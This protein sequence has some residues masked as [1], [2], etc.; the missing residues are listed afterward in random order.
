MTRISSYG[1]YLTTLQTITGGQRNID[2]LSEQLNTGKKATD[3]SYFGTQAQRL[4]D[5]RAEVVRRTGYSSTIDQTMTRVKSYNTLMERMSDMATEL[6]STSRLPAGPG[7]PR[8]SAVTNASYPSLKVS[9]E[10]TGSRFTVEATYTVTAVP[11]ATGK[12]G[13]F[14]ITVTDGLGGKST[15]TVNLTQVP[16]AVDAD[17][18]TINGGPGSGA[19][20]KLN[21]DELKGGGTSSFTVTYPELTATKELVK[22]MTTELEALLNERVGDRYLFSGSR[23]NTKPVNDLTAAKQVM[24]TTLV[25]QRGD[26]GEVYEMILNG[27][28]FTYTTTGAEGSLDEV[29]T[30][31]SGTGL[32]D[33]IKAATPPFNVTVG[34][35]NG[36]VTVAGITAS[37]KFSL[38]TRVYDNGTHN[39]IVLPPAGAVNPGEAPYTTQQATDLLPQIDQLKLH[40]DNADIGDVFNI[41]I[42]ARTIIENEGAPPQ[43]IISGPQKYAYVVGPKDTEVMAALPAVPPSQ[44][45][46][47][48]VFTA[49]TSMA[50]WVAQNLAVQIN[51]DPSSTVTASIDPADDTNII[52]TSKQ[53]NSQFQTTA[54]INNAGNVN[55]LITKDIPPLAEQTVFEDNKPP[56]ALAFYDSEYVTLGSST[57]AY[58]LATMSPDEGLRV[59][60]GVTSNDPAIQKLVAGLRRLTAAVSRPGDYTALMNEGRELL[61]DAKNELRS[62]QSRVVNAA[63]TMDNAQSRHQDSITKAKNEMGTIEGVD[64]NEVAVKLQAALS[65][66]EAAY[67]IAG[68][69]QSLSL[70]NFLT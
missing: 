2:T 56:P 13:T 30:N 5:L 69:L 14:D 39:N 50:N 53:P 55:Q 22:S 28:R 31:A 59:V 45:G 11:S 21:F 64:P 61:I 20:I 4:L 33:Q 38:S 43:V 24:R 66:Q 60:Y 34:V 12:A 6:S 46:Q 10:T 9:V 3:I 41:E 68:R 44:P 54:G 52:L 62:V 49:P 58:D 25:G 23:L 1:S 32:V 8:I 63:S 18:F 36:I 16:P 40:G 65:S 26:P 70:I 42:G 19:V 35:S 67:T 57:A 7:T 51:A 15:N 47:N 37:D 48:P 17:I 27:K 29:L